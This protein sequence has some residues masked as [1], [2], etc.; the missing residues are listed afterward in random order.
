VQQTFHASIWREGDWFVAQCIEID[1]ASQGE[2]EE[3]ALANLGEALRLHLAPP[4][5]TVVPVLRP[6]AVNVTADAA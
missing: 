3:A 2:S 1:V 4:H 5:P 6:I